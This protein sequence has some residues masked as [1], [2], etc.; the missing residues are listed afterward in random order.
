MDIKRYE[1]DNQKRATVRESLAW[2]CLKRLVWLEREMG[3]T[4]GNEVTE[5]R[6][7]GGKL[8]VHRYKSFG[9]YYLHNCILKKGMT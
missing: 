4:V 8:A 9:F 6:D 5:V 2:R 7:E 3:K 1:G